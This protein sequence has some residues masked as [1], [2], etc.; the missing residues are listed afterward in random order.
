MENP[1]FRNPQFRN[2]QFRTYV[3]YVIL[4]GTD[5]LNNVKSVMLVYITKACGSIV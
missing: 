2:P 5:F 3:A 1:Q 4:R